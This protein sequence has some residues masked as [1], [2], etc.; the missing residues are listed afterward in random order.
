[1]RFARASLDPYKIP[2]KNGIG[3]IAHGSSLGGGGYVFG[4]MD[5]A[6]KS[7]W[8]VDFC[9]KLSRFTDF[10]YTVDRGSAVNF[11]VDSGLCL[12]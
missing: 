6:L 2:L 8:I 1:V 4:S 10:E 12:S 9:S 5:L 11:D 3:S 7:T